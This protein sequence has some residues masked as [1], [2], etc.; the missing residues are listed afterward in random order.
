MYLDAHTA[1]VLVHLGPDVL[2]GL[3]RLLQEA[4]RE[5]HPEADV[6]SAAAPQPRPLA[7][8]GVGLVARAPIQCALAARSG[9]LVHQ[10][11]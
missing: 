1:V 8:H 3:V 2:A 9:K 11:R 5:L 10:P 7:L 4:A 6:V